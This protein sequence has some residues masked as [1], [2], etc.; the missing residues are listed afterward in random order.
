MTCES[1]LWGFVSYNLDNYGLFCTEKYTL[2]QFPNTILIQWKKKG[3]L[4]YSL[5]MI[6]SRHLSFTRSKIIN[7]EI[8]NPTFA[9]RRRD[10]GQFSIPSFTSWRRFTFF[11]SR[12]S[13]SDKKKVELTSTGSTKKMISFW[14]KR[15]NLGCLPRTYRTTRLKIS[16]INI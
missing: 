1:S 8:N 4:W 5:P 7:N 3:P 9:R 16:I 15:R 11:R 10:L 6:P 13:F 2:R 12:P 14:L